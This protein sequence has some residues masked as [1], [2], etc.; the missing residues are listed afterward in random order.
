MNQDIMKVE[1]GQ[2]WKDNDP[3]MGGAE[4]VVIEV[5]NTHA[6]IRR[7]SGMET[8]IRLDRFR[9]TSTGFVFVR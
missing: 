5:G 3:R 8:K 7:P 2:V 4:V 6:R 9:P 1:V